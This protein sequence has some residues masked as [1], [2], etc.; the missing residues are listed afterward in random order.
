MKNVFKVIILLM[1][2]FVIFVGCSSPQESSS[3]GS[4]DSQ[5]SESPEGI[6]FDIGD[7][8]ADMTPITLDGQGTNPDYLKGY[9][10]GF[11]YNYWKDMQFGNVGSSIM[12]IWDSG[13]Y[14]VWSGVHGT[15]TGKGWATGKTNLVLT[16]IGWSNSNADQNGVDD[17]HYFGIYGWADNNWSSGHPEKLIEYYVIETHGTKGHGLDY[18]GDQGE[19]GT[20][21]ISDGDWYY[22]YKTRRVNKP[23]IRGFQDFDQYWATRFNQRNSGTITF[24]NHVNAWGSKWTQLQNSMMDDSELTYQLLFV[25]APYDANTGTGNGYGYIQSHN[26]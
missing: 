6:P 3:S 4:N 10:G 18:D 7:I 19:L 1:I 12:Y 14:T 5:Q 9:D 21:Y 8:N 22:T 11:F 16:F 2:V 15:V 24:Q 13:F 26:R 17:D 23:S 25:E 20:F